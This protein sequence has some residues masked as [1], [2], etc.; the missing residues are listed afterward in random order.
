MSDKLP[1]LADARNLDELLKSL[2]PAQRG[3]VKE[4]LDAAAKQPMGEF[5]ALAA[6]KILTE[7]LPPER[8]AV[9]VRSLGANFALIAKSSSYLAQ[10]METPQGRHSVS[11]AVAMTAISGYAPGVPGAPGAKAWIIPRKVGGCV[12]VNWQISAAGLRAMAEEDGYLVTGAGIFAGD[13]LLLPSIEQP[14]TL[15]WEP[16]PGGDCAAPGEPEAPWSPIPVDDAAPVPPSLRRAQPV[17]DWTNL[18]GFLVTARQIGGAEIRAWRLVGR[19]VILIRRRESD[20]YQRALKADKGIDWSNTW[21][22]WPLEMAEKAAI[23]YAL[24]RGIVTLSDRMT[25]VLSFDDRAE[26]V[27]VIDVPQAKPRIALP[28]NRAVAALSPPSLDDDTA[29]PTEAQKAAIR[30]E[31]AREAGDGRGK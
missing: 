7:I 15:A 12:T 27:E 24:R 22:K 31:E 18:A 5:V 1:A 16:A 19:E 14:D 10:A 28:P 2:P 13:L 30:A 25:A 4:A 3:M 29:E 26:R 21:L 23:S 17:R 8:V 20:A 6:T 11:A 9:A